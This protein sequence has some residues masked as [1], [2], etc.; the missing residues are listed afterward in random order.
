MPADVQCKCQVVLAIR[1]LG[2]R[3]TG[4]RRMARS[5]LL[6]AM[7]A[8]I[9]GSA[10]A[11]SLT[12]A[13]YGG[14]WGEAIQACIL[15]PFTKATGTKVTPDPGVSTV[16]LSKLRQQKGSPVI[17]IAWI[18]GG[19]SEL[20][21]ADGL[22]EDLTP[23]AVP[24]M[25]NMLTEGVYKTSGGDVFALSTGFYSMGLV[26]NTK[27]VKNPP[28][29]FW[30]L[31]KPEFDGVSTVP[32][33]TNAMGVPLF[34]HLNR[35]AGG[36][37]GD[38][39]PAVDKYKALKVSSFFDAS[40]AATNSFQSGEVTVG[41]HYASAAWSLADKGL[42]ITYIAP[43]EGAPTGDIRVHLVKGTKNKA[44]AEKFIDFAVAKEQ[45]ACMTEKL[46]VGPATKGITLTD[47]AKS[48]LPWGKDGSIANLALIN[49]TELNA[50]RQ[51][52]TD[53]WTKEVARK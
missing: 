9:N 41:A 36:K 43:K 42:P 21:S 47:K 15:D 23:A 35:A 8:F 6:I 38:Y 34:M 39:K 30:D 14:E 2:F 20:A 51:A 24:N 29:S 4:M 3:E 1:E 13:V 17:D 37:V 46:Y 49:W 12:A 10:H 52:I 44:L 27:E 5:S 33:P 48:R 53:L 16:T 25:A 45:A 11:Q 40:G 22:L 32:S 19:V 50:Q 18:D 7:G 26:Y 31:W 28:T